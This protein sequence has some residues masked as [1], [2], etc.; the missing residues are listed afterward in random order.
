[1]TSLNSQFD[2]AIAE[3]ASANEQFVEA[4]IRASRAR[5]EEY[6]CLAHVNKAQKEF[7][8]LVQLVKGHAPRASDWKCRGS[9]EVEE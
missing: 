9:V 1:M 6:A 8:T 7:D 3:L 4:A 5:S 2:A